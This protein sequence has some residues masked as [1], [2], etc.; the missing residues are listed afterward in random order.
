MHPKTKAI[1]RP[2]LR[3]DNKS[4]KKDRNFIRKRSLRAGAR[5]GNRLTTSVRLR[6]GTTVT[7]ES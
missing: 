6:A 7:V 1:L 4:P 5:L 3:L 2:I